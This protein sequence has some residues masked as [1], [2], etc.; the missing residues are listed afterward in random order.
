MAVTKITYASDEAVVITNWDS[1]AADA[2]ASL[3]A[4][5]NATNLYVDV[6]AGGQIDWTATTLA[7]GESF[8]IYVSALST[9]A[10][11]SSYTGGIDTLLTAGD[12]SLTED[13]EFTPLN[14]LLLATVAV[15]TGTPDVTLGYNWGPTS[16]AGLFGGVM[17]QKYMFMGHNNTGSALTAT[18]STTFLNLV[19]ITYTTAA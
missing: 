12:I 4:V 14:L 10:T 15:R 13:T 8:D 6:L 17:P 11:A 9:I 7:A 18:T 3:P 16:I 19:G 5:D 2:W 1:L